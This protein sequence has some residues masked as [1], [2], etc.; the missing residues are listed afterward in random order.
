MKIAVSAIEPSL[1]ADVDPRFGRCRYL[2]VIDL[3]T[4]QF[5]AIENTGGM[6]SGG[7][8]IATA[9]MIA[10]K[11]VEAVITGNCGPN[12]YQVLSAAGIKVVTGVSGKVQDA[13]QSYK[14]GKLKTSSQPNVGGHFGL[15][16]GGMGRGMRRGM[17]R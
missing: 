15:G 5:E 7:A 9:Q 14:S 17:G 6:A 4:M 13:V 2:L 10:G 16:Y 12:A 3:D 8:G 11:G 1:D